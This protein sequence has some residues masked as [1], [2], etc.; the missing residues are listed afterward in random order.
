[1]RL[2]IVY[3]VHTNVRVHLDKSQFNLKC[4]LCMKVLINFQIMNIRISRNMSHEHQNRIGKKDSRFWYKYK[5]VNS[6]IP[7][8]M[9]LCVCGCASALSK[10]SDS[11]CGDHMNRCELSINHLDYRQP[12]VSNE[13]VSIVFLLFIVF[14][15]DS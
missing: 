15:V 8:F 6:F 11:F 2:C 3:I 5:T 10:S 14:S 13:R 4:N 7:V 1:M 9:Y 12:F